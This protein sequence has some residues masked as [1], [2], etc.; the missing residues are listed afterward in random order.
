MSQIKLES[1]N[2]R[3][4][5]PEEALDLFRVAVY[6]HDLKLQEAIIAN[7]IIPNMSASSAV[8]FLKETSEWEVISPCKKVPN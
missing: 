3:R 8:L 4:G 7:E 1:Q 6:F 5:R 2:N